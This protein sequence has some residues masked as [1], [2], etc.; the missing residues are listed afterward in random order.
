[1]VGLLSLVPDTTTVLGV[2][3]LV[4]SYSMMLLSHGGTVKL[5]PDTATV[6]GVK[7]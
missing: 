4:C 6:L 3:M 7:C 1:M 2:Q 5:V